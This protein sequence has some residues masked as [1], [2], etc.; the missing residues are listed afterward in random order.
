M[1]RDADDSALKKAYRKLAIKYHPDKNPDNPTAEE[2]FK[3]V[4]EAYDCLSDPQKRAAYDNYGKEGAKMA[5]QGG[6]PGGGMR[7]GGGFHGHHVDPE[8]LFRQFFNQTGGG[9]MRGGGARAQ[10]FHF[11]GNGGGAQFFVNGVPMGGRRRQRQPQQEQQDEEGVQQINLPPFVQAILQ[12][13]PPPLLVMAFFFLFMFAMQVAGAGMTVLMARMHMV[14][15]ILWFAPD[16]MKL[17][18]I[19]SVFLLSAMGSL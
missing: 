14:M 6:F 17:P 12:T 13:V 18:L 1:S 4:A 16:R 10:T 7:R 8:E 9:G 5:E 19:M 11:G 2:N 3:R 15:P